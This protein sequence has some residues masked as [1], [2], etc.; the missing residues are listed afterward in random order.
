MIESLSQEKGNLVIN[1]IQIRKAELILKAID[2]DLRE[3]I[4]RF[5]DE[6][7]EVPVT[8]IYKTLGIEQ[9][10]ASQHLANNCFTV[11]INVDVVVAL[12]KFTT[13]S[14][15]LAIDCVLFS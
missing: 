3:K 1:E 5:I 13:I 12:N 9:S 11:I 6:H 8:A 2:H 7:E 14:L 15:I 10:V 4:L